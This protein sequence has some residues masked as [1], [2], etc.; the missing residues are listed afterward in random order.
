MTDRSLRTP[1]AVRRAG[2]IVAV[3][4]IAGVLAAVVYVISGIREATSP[5]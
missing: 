1:K 2:A 3:Q 4:G 5:D